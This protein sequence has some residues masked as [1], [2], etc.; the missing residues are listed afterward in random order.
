MW[1]K[2]LGL[3]DDPESQKADAQENLAQAWVSGLTDD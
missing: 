3:L 2:D 1:L